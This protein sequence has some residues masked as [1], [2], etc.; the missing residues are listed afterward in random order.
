MLGFREKSGS[1]SF[2]SDS[3]RLGLIGCGGRLTHVV[4]LLCTS[5][6]G[7]RVVALCD[8]SEL[9]VSRCREALRDPAIRVHETAESLCKATDV[10]WV[11]VGSWNSLH[12]DHVVAAW[13]AG[14]RVFCEKPLATSLEDCVRLI[15]EQ[16]R[17][18]GE[19]TLGLVLRYAP[20]Y[21]RIRELVQQGALGQLMSFEFNETLDYQ[22]GGYIAGDWR[23]WRA[24]AGTHVMEKC[25]HDLD[26]SNWITGSLPVRAA[27][28]GGLSFFRPENAGRVEA[29][30]PDAEGRPA[31]M[32][33]QDSGIYTSENRLNPFLADK[34][35]F[36][37]QVAILEYASGARATFHTNLNSAL[38]ERRM[39]LCGTEGGL[40]GDVLTGEIV[41]KRIGPETE[42]HRESYPSGGH[43]GADKVLAA[44]WADVMMRD[45][46]PLAGLREGLASAIAALGIDEAADTGTVCDL[47]PMWAKVGMADAV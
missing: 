4:R 9:A 31:Y 34:D 37:H 5:N 21:Q 13:R 41:W 28:F 7:I 32:S 26:L 44:G 20:F 46:K 25:C 11:A 12:A 15:G 2:M 17:L 19:L 33:W 45:A 10:D 18:H 36:D 47:R 6:P 30:G 38:P 1:F 24:N 27:S 23:R 29:V 3:I 43:G 22:H 39:Y 8:P 14:K 35:I 40:R 16:R 42:T